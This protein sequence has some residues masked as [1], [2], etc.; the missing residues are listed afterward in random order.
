ML[1]QKQ[2]EWLNTPFLNLINNWSLT[3]LLYGMLWGFTILDLQ[4]FLIAHTLFQAIE[5]VCFFGVDQFSLQDEL[6]DAALG[7]LGVLIT[8]FSPK[9]SVLFCSVFIGTLLSKK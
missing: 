4:S 7:V 1:S 2:I 5:L 9:S 8:K 3:H 6:L